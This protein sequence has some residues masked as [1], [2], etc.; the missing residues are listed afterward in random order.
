MAEPNFYSCCICVAQSWVASA[1]GCAFL[2]FGK[3]LHDAWPGCRMW[4]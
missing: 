3:S 4:P 2:E 1:S